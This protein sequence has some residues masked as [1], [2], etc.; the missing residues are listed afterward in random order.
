[1]KVWVLSALS[2]LTLLLAGCSSQQAAE[3]I[4]WP[5]EP[6]VNF[7]ETKVNN[8]ENVFRTYRKMFANGWK[9]TE[10][11]GQLIFYKRTETG[12]NYFYLYTE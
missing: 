3:F 5:M 2:L 1:M 12:T 8:N 10:K 6:P 9:L 4:F 7:E 11:D